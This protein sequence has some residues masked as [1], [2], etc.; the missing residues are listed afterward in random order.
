MNQGFNI[1]NRIT[2]A[3]KNSVMY[4]LNYYRFWDVYTN[5]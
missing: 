5:S 1:D 4:K 3:M 2:D